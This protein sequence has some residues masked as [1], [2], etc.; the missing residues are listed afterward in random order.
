MVRPILDAFILGSQHP[1]TTFALLLALFGLTLRVPAVRDPLLAAARRS[2]PGLMASLG[3]ITI[4]VFVGV[5]IWY[6]SIAA[7]ACEVEPLIASVS[8]L[9]KEGQPLYHAIDAAE[10]YSV[11]Y[12]PSVYLTNGL[13][14]SLLGPSIVAAKIGSL[15]AAV[16]S[17][18]FLFLALRSRLALRSAL[19]LA[20]LAVL[21]Y[22]ESGCSAYLVRPD[23]PLL[24]AVAFGLL[25]ARRAPAR[26]AWLGVAAALGFAVNLKIHSGL[27]FLP[28]LVLLAGRH[29]GRRTALAVAGGGLLVLAPFVL[30]PGISLR[31]YLAWVVVAS[32][33]G[34][35]P[36]ALPAL[37]RHALFFA[38]PLIVVLAAGGRLDPRRRQ[39]RWLLT[40]YLLANVGIVILAAKPGAGLVHLLPLATLG[41]VLAGDGLADLLARPVG[42][43]RFSPLVV[44]AF[45]ATAAAAVIGGWV[46]E[47][48]SVRQAYAQV[49]EAPAIRRD[50]ESILAAYPDRTVGM[51][52]G[53][54]GANFRRTFLRPLLT[55]SGQPLLLDAIAV[56][57]AEKAGLDL[58][59]ATF[60][61]LDAGRI[62]VWLVPRRAHPFE[63]SNWY[64]P[65]HTL[66]SP[67]FRE[68]FERCYRLDRRTDFFDCWVWRGGGRTGRTAL[69]VPHGDQR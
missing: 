63:K 20:G 10:R 45:A 36:S 51:G 66:F 23:A 55:F 15:L 59:A 21:F 29:G 60:D 48:R 42:W 56:M 37:V 25:C 52:Y 18:A 65:H 1:L 68:H 9:L 19:P 22:W 54:E 14:L 34:L 47:Y 5:G 53:G 58:P 26:L 62:Q 50:L 44:G 17:L 13:F 61:A 31:N 2:G 38:L 24:A 30:H 43:P 69:A 3:A 6:A 46:T 64:A 7:F 67:D 33:H 40:T 28:V 11:V 12:G 32:G 41:V 39:H 49:A 16:A 35:D 8:W 27:Y 57:D 4:L